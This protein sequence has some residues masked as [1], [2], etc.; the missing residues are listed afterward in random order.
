MSRIGSKEGF[1]VPKSEKQIVQ[2]IV[3]FLNGLERC[4]AVKNHG[5]AFAVAGRPDI[6]ACYRGF[7]LALE[8]KR[9]QP[10]VHRHITVQEIVKM[11]NKLHQRWA[12]MGATRKQIYELEQ[13]RQ[14]G[15]IADVV[16]SVEDV[17]DLIDREGLDYAV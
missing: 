10:Y 9:P 8:V 6:D 11:K 15:S 12:E 7:H 17:R 13:W 2:D 1:A 16:C 5:S 3:G 14:A 4:R